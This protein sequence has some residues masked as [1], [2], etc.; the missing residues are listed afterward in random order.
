MRVG[1]CVWILSSEMP[2]YLTC[3]RNFDP[4]YEIYKAKHEGKPLGD[5][6]SFTATTLINGGD[7]KYNFLK[8]PNDL[9]LD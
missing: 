1:S 9:L 4:Y 6:K 3:S 7:I 5:K 2:L 8:K